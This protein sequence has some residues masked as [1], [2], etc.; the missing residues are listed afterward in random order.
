MNMFPSTCTWN[1]VLTAVED[2]IVKTPSIAMK[3]R[4][5]LAKT[6]VKSKYGVK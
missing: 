5:F 3:T 4:Q 2:P 1:V 6:D